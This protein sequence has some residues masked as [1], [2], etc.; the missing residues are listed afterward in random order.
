M[1]PSELLE[2]L[3]EALYSEKGLRVREEHGRA[4]LL[5][6]RFYA[7]RQSHSDLKLITITHCPIDPDHELYLIRRPDPD[8]KNGD[9]ETLDQ[10]EG[11]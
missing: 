3:Y 8:A 9:D 7:A 10:S 2:M 6:K 1:T 11:G 4:D 5:R